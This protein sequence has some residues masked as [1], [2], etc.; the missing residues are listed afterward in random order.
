LCRILYKPEKII[1]EKTNSFDKVEIFHG[2][3]NSTLGLWITLNTAFATVIGLIGLF[4]KA[5]AA[6]LSWA[7]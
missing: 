2:I 4:I 1:G 3:I 5:I 7:S 6:S